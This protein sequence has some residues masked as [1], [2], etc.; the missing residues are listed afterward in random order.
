MLQILEPRVIGQIR[1]LNTARGPVSLLGDDDL[2]LAF[3]VF[4]LAVVVLLAMNEAHDVSILLDRARH[5]Q[6]DQQRLLI[7]ATLLTRT[8]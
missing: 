6:I 2:G 1:K 3:Q 8:R 5:P 4:V 7:P